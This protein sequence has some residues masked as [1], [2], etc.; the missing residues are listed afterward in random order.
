MIQ[1]GENRRIGRETTV[2]TTFSTIKRIRTDLASNPD[3][4]LE[5]TA[6]DF[7]EAAKVINIQGSGNPAY[8]WDD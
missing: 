8:S 1:T 5:M 4:L 6:N 7:F 3:L 2:A